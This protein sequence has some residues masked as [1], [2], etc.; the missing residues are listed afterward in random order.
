MRKV[1]SAPKCED[2]VLHTEN[3]MEGSPEANDQFELMGDLLAGLDVG[4]AE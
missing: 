4:D 3:V 1:Y 2:I